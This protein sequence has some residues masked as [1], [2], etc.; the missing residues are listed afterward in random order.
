VDS[1][2]VFSVLIA[3]EAGSAAGFGFLS[4]SARLLRCNHANDL[5][6]RNRASRDVVDP[7]LCRCRY[8]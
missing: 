2:F 8:I 1:P 3:W 5:S 4:R 7:Y 6:C